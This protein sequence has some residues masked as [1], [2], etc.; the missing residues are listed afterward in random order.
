[1]RERNYISLINNLIFFLQFLITL[2][3]KHKFSFISYR[4]KEQLNV[5]IIEFK[6]S[7]VYVQY[8][9]NRELC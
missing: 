3:D 9:I 2:E 5:A 6:N 8:I 4:N 7:L 1:M